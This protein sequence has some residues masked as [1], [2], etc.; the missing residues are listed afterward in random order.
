MCCSR[1]GDHHAVDQN[2]RNLD[3]P[4]RQPAALGDPLDLGD[5]DAVAVLGRHGHGQVV[6]GQCF[7]FH[8]DVAEGIGGGAAHEGDID[9]ADLVEQPLLAIDLDQ[10]D[11]VLGGPGIDPATAVA[12]I[13][14][15]MQSDLGERTRLA[16]GEIPEQLADDALRQ[17]VG[18]DAVVE[19]QL[20]DLRHAAPVARHHPAQQAFV[21]E[22]IEPQ[23]LAVALAGGGEQGQVRGLPV[24]RKRRSSADSRASA[25]PVW[26]KPVLARVSPSRIRAIA[27]SAVTIL[28]RML[29]SSRSSR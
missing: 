10:A 20:R 4:R 5:D 17:V 27:S 6:E 28:L 7:A 25:K 1:F 2:P 9:L 15:G 23:G 12:G 29:V 22:V 18:L 8:G 19:C 13:D 3:L 16:G 11:D 21:A 24:A 26:T 14:E